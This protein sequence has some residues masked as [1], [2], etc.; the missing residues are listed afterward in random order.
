[1]DFRFTLH[2]SM[3][4][5]PGPKEMNAI[6]QDSNWNALNRPHA[7]ASLHDNK[8]RLVIR[9]ALTHDHAPDRCMQQPSNLPHRLL[10]R[11]NGASPVGCVGRNVS[12]CNPNI[13]QWL[14]W[15]HIFVGKQTEKFSN[16]HV[17]DEARVEIG[18]AVGVGAIS[19]VP[20]WINP[21]RMI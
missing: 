11:S 14:H 5:L 7:S 10:G 20:E 3:A 19:H 9:Y 1:M 18:P 17:M 21:M 6:L 4:A 8:L 16:G 2:A 15:F 12:V 13:D